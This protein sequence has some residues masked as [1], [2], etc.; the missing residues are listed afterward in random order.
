[1]QSSASPEQLKSL[2]Q[3]LVAVQQST[4]TSL[5]IFI[6]PHNWL[7]MHSKWYYNWHLFH[8]VR[9]THVLILLVYLG[10]IGIYA[11]DLFTPPPKVTTT[12]A[13]VPP[14]ETKVVPSPRSVIEQ[15]SKKSSA[16]ATGAL[17]VTIVSFGVIVGIIT[18][19][20][21]SHQHDEI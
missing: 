15:P 5:P 13:V 19:I 6:K 14:S 4:S 10:A 17:V 1:M 18:H 2:E 3:R 9:F 12:I 20:V 7:R 8:Y 16:A 21:T 11:Y